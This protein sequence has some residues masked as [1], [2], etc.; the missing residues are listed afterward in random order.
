MSLIVPVYF[1]ELSLSPLLEKILEAVRPL[2]DLSFEFI[3]VDDGSRDG[4]LK[5]L[6][7]WNQKVPRVKILKLTRNFGSQNAIIAGLK[8]ASG[9]C[10]IVIGADLQTPPEILSDFL[11]EWKAGYKIVVGRRLKRRDPWV[12]ILLAN[13]YYFLIR[14]SVR[15]LPK[16][17]FD[18]FLIDRRMKDYLLSIG[19]RNTLLEVSILWSGYPVKEVPYIRMERPFGKS[20]WTFQRKIK[21]AI[22][23]LTAYSYLP[24]LVLIL[25]GGLLCALSCVALVLSIGISDPVTYIRFS[26]YFI[27]L[28]ILGGGMNFLGLGLLGE[29]LWRNLEETRKFPGYWVER[30]IGFD[31]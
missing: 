17:G 12:T 21:L 2:E 3:F 23:S 27:P 4:S 28:S 19:S 5:V 10:H 1:N 11:K 29:Y 20:R 16:G 31:K 25:T 15:N 6:E 22:D 18:A 7:G 9:D 8:R 26:K 24:I 13:F 14:G 30:E